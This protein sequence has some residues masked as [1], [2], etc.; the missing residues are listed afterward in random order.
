MKQ[1][2]FTLIEVMVSI[3][4]LA[5]IMVLLWSSTGQSL[6]A[7]ERFERRDGIYHEGRVS[8][9]K[10]ADDLSMAFLIRAPGTRAATAAAAAGQ[11]PVAEI[12]TRPRPITFFIGEDEGERDAVRFTSLSNLRLFKNAKTS[13]QAKIN[14]KVVADEEESDKFNLVRTY[15]PWLDEKDT[16][17][18]ASYVVAEN[19]REFNVEY[20][21]QRKQEWV[22]EWNST[23]IDW[24]DR[25][26]RAVRITI[27]F[28][29]PDDDRESIVMATATLLPMSKGPIDF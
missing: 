26:P 25:L 21:D 24:R 23:L 20:Y 14:Y 22:R 8:L 4:I 10:M 29:D 1:S 12:A 19:I 16:V 28:P 2:G 6:N 27:S 9:R 17:E 15:S 5:F 3:A 7:K 18:G 11:P 13:D